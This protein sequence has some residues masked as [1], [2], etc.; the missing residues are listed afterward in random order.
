MKKI[1]AIV[2]GALITLLGLM[3][4]PL[5]WIIGVLINWLWCGEPEHEEGRMCGGCG[6][7]KKDG[8]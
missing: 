6:P 3:L 2:G 1:G 8:E 4:L 5:V 7:I